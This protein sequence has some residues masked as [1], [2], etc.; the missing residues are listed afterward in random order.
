MFLSGVGKL[1]SGDRVWADLTALEYHYWTQPLPHV[2]SY[3]VDRLPAWFHRASAFGM[4]VIEVGLPFLVFGP[5]RL[6][7]LAGLC[8][9]FLMAAIV[10][11]GNYGFFEPLTCVL[12][13]TLFDDRALRA[14]LCRRATVEPA[15]E[16]PPDLRSTALVAVPVALVLLLTSIPA[17]LR[18]GVIDS[19]PA[20]LRPLVRVT[21][22]FSSFNSYGLFTVMTTERPEILLEGSQD[23]REWKA[24]E[25]RWKPGA[26]DRAPRFAWAHMPR[27]DWQMWFSALQDSPRDAWYFA[28]MQKLLEGEPAVLRLLAENPFED[29][30]PRYIRATR[31]RY[32]FSSPEE[33]ARGLW[34]HRV[35]PKPYCPTLE[36]ID[37]RLTPVR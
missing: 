31:W 13:V 34:W 1:V 22:P 33:R 30:P 32:T 37:G 3:W 7:Q 29:A 17:S 23:G 16:P 8:F 15:G 12:C 11:T 6:R 19:V 2:L 9:L 20:L 26:L 24:Y 18:L 4:F 14:V 28:F 27:L 35:D 21:Q 10:A 36:I 5:R 25:F